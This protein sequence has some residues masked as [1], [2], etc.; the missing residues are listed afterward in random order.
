MAFKIRKSV[1]PAGVPPWTPLGELT[2]FPRP[3]SL[4]GEGTTSPYPPHSARSVPRF[5]G[6]RRSALAAGFFCGAFF[7]GEG[8]YC[9]QIFSSRTAAVRLV[10]R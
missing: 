6:L 8:G 9:P 5:S 2:T 4:L 3:L 10:I 1:L 7:W